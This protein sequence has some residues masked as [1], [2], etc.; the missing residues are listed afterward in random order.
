M[1]K[2][3]F[4]VIINGD[5]MAVVGII[6]YADASYRVSILNNYDIISFFQGLSESI[7]FNATQRNDRSLRLCDW[8]RLFNAC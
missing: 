3:K 1:P 4:E 6:K 2:Q 5:A 7:Q 8:E